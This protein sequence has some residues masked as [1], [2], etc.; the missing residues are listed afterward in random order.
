ML[1]IPIIARFDDPKP[2]IIHFF[3]LLVFIPIYWMAG[4]RK[5]QTS[6]K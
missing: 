6:D 4:K 3:I 1:P 5:L 2:S